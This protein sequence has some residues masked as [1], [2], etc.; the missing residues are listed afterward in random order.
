VL[1]SQLRKENTQAI[2]CVLSRRSGGVVQWK[3]VLHYDALDCVP[4]DNVQHLTNAISNSNVPFRAS[5]VVA[6]LGFARLP[7]PGAL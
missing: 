1:A 6:V 4:E 3:Q 2:S 7:S 5:D